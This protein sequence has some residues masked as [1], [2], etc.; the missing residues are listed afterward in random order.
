MLGICSARV[1]YLGQWRIYFLLHR[2]SRSVRRYELDE[3]NSPRH[4]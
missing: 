4:L 1:D 3:L 2:G